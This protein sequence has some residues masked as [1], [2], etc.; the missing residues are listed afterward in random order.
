MGLLDFFKRDAGPELFGAHEA[1][2]AKAAALRR[3]IDRLMP[4]NE[5]TVQVDGDKVKIA[6]RVPD[7]AT[8]EKLALI[9]GNARHVGQVDDQLEPAA[10][11]TQAAGQ[12]RPAG[13]AGSASAQT[14]PVEQTSARFYTVESGDTLSK[15]AKAYYGDPDAYRLIFEANRPMLS[16]PDKIYPGQVL[17]IPSR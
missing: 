2:E 16:D 11:P 1:A 10:S 15:I 5:L 4:G 9:V 13:Q 17:R 6:G 7:Q 8:K 14:I 12:S 3:E